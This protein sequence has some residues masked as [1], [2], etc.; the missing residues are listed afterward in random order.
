MS[1]DQLESEDILILALEFQYW[2]EKKNNSLQYGQV[3]H[4]MY[5]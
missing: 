4:T 3:S 5:G 1:L 2:H